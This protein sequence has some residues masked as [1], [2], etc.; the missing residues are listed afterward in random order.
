MGQ[1]PA[2]PLHDPFIAAL[3]GALNH[4]YDP[5][6]LRQCD[7]ARTFKLSGRVDTSSALQS[8][9]TRAIES[10]HPA[11]GTPNKAHAQSIYELLLYRYVQQFNQ[12]EI[13]N[14]LGISVRHLR[15]QQNLAID[16]LA[17]MLRKQ[18]PLLNSDAETQITPT[19]PE[20]MAFTE[21]FNWVRETAHGAV[22]EL[23]LAL[24][25]IHT[26]IQS[27]VDQRDV[28]L[29]FPQDLTG[30]VAVHPV[31]FQQILLNLLSLFIQNAVG[32]TVE[33]SVQDAGD[34]QVF[35]LRRVSPAVEAP[36]TIE[37]QQWLETVQALVEMSQG[38]LIWRQQKTQ[39]SVAVS[40]LS[41]ARRVVLAIDDNAEII[42]M[43]QRFTGETCYRVEG[44][45][46]PQMAIEYAL[47]HQPDII[48]VDIMMPQV[49]GLQVLSRFRHHPMLTKIPILVCSVLPQQDLAAALGASGFLQKPIRRE[50]FLAAL[51]QVLRSAP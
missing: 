27:L 49:D 8:I 50:P 16:E 34:L 24:A 29:I 37:V 20:R 7:L 12:D 13:A 4:L 3:R 31:A 47:Q 19:A 35:E 1:K 41:V 25:A 21:E 2:L 18:H 30:M 38:T 44:V 26:T 17:V 5:D 23:E 42:T 15:R 43:M 32:G 39:F 40:F 36:L 22:T 46:D 48:V 10:L 6:F 14:Q 51:E 9:L 28:H 45:T 33:L 11:A